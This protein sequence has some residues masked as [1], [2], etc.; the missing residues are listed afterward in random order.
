MVTVEDIDAD[1]QSEVESECGKFG[2]VLKVVIYQEKQSEADNAEV[3][4]KIFVEF[5]VNTEADQAIS[6][7]D[8]RY[9]GGNK[10]IAQL[11]DPILYK[12]NDFSS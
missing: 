10:V 6:S 3:I 9:F 12:T 2:N 11:Y 7:L 8:G 5:E 1:L 4:V